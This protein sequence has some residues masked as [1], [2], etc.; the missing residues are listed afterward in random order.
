[1]LSINYFLEMQDDNILIGTG[2]GIKGFNINDKS[3]VDFKTFFNSKDDYFESL[4]VYSFY[5][6]KDNRIWVGTRN[7]GLYIYD[8]ESDKV[9]DVAKD[10]NIPK[11][12]HAVVREMVLDD[13]DN[14][15]VAT[16]MGLCCL[17]LKDKLDHW[18]DKLKKPKYT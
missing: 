7:S 14:M 2:S 13:Y 12:E 15:W 16:N 8:I 9:I 1:M 3:I 5:H 17:N 6:D 18:R 4:Y 11:L 10:Y